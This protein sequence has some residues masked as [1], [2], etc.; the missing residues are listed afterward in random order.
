MAAD[1]EHPTKCCCTVGSRR[2]ESP[3]ESL[4]PLRLLRFLG[5][6]APCPPAVRSLRYAFRVILSIGFL[7]LLGIL[8][9]CNEGDSSVCGEEYT[10]ADCD[11]VPNDRDRCA[12]TPRESLH[13]AGGCAPTQ[14][15]TCV[16]SPRFPEADQEIDLEGLD[17]QFRWDGTCEGYVLYLSP[18]STFPAARTVALARLSQPVALL[19]HEQWTQELREEG[20]GPL[21]WQVR[22]GKE[23]REFVSETRRVVLTDGKSP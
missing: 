22:G 14:V 10:D 7:S 12:E 20:E 1:R 23:G 16:V 13:D 3:Q 15:T 21:Y 8:G 2:R 5:P 19:T 9:G 11:G 18:D 17:L 6:S 4:R